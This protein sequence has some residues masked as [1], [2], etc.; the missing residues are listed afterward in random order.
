MKYKLKTD[1]ALEVWYRCFVQQ[2]C[3]IMN[4]SILTPNIYI[5]NKNEG[6]QQKSGCSYTGFGITWCCVYVDTL[7]G[8]AVV[9]SF[10]TRSAEVECL[11]KDQRAAGWSLT[12]VTALLSLS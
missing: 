7:H 9:K 8:L 12:G 5:N 3:T 10:L 4:I 1:F 2:R 11:T 6:K